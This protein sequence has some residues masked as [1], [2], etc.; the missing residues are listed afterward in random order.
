MKS[1]DM[2]KSRCFPFRAGFLC[3]LLVAALC[4]LCPAAHAQQGDEAESGQTAREQDFEQIAGAYF[5][6]GAYEDAVAYYLKA[7]EQNPDNEIL[8]YNIAMCYKE[9]KSC[10]AATHFEEYL[11]LTL[12][13]DDE[14]EVEQWIDSIQRK[15][16]KR[17]D[18]KK[19]Q[20]KQAAKEKAL[21]SNCGVSARS[22]AYDIAQRA[23]EGCAEGMIINAVTHLLGGLQAIKNTDGRRVFTSTSACSY[24][25][26]SDQSVMYFAFRIFDH[27]NHILLISMDRD[28]AFRIRENSRSR[29]EME[30]TIGIGM[31][32]DE[33]ITSK[34]IR[35]S[36]AYS[37]FRDEK[38]PDWDLAFKAIFGLF[39]QTGVNLKINTK[40]FD[41]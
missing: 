12:N 10:K 6:Q 22:G 1:A 18:E 38:S 29:A 2:L 8:H 27:P 15:C 14:L 19:E 39:E 25:D 32:F 28:R 36:S 9:M 37:F 3:A 17:H 16:E 20:K 41:M 4:C 35:N 7:I 30:Y 31:Y 13:P 23:G 21:N 40:E 5:D 26:P 33:K 24:I 11:A 34:T